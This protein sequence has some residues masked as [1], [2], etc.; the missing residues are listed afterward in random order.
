[1]DL[2]LAHHGDEDIEGLLRDAV[3]FLDVEQRALAQRGQQRSIDEDVGR[4][5]LGQ[6]AGGVEMP[7]ETRRGELGVALDELESD[8]E[9]TGHRTQQRR[10]PGARGTLEE[11]VA[12]GREGGEHQLHL[13]GAADDRATDDRKEA[14]DVS[15]RWRRRPWHRRCASTG[16]PR[17]QVGGARQ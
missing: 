10:F 15:R 8:A 3:D 9:T 7:H 13:P 4:I 11:H 14:G 12:I 6:D 5:A 17:R 1:V 16:V 2:P